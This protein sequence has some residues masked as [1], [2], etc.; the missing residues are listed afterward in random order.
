MAQEDEWAPIEEE[1]ESILVD[2]RFFR[3]TRALFLSIQR[4]WGH[5]TLGSWQDDSCV[6]VY[7]EWGCVDMSP[8]FLFLF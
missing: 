1:L 5:H 2:A 6:I 3:L 8:F 7:L 4:E